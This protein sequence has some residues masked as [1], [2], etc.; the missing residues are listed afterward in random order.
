MKR[1]GGREAAQP[2]RQNSV[3]KSFLVFFF[4]ILTAPP[5]ALENV[6]NTA[7]LCW[8][9]ASHVLQRNEALARVSIN[10]KTPKMKLRQNFEMRSSSQ[11]LKKWSVPAN[12]RQPDLKWGVITLD[13]AAWRQSARPEL[14]VS[15]LHLHKDVFRQPATHLF[16]KTQVSS[17]GQPLI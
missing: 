17:R 4:Y 7:A 2:E 10:F 11:V 8:I 16:F 6:S 9:E 5:G 3:T 15:Q 1:F 14:I 12:R 13:Q